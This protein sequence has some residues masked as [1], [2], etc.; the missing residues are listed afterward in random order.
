MLVLFT[1]DTHT[2]LIQR[3]NLSF[4]LETCS[5]Y[6]DALFVA[7]FAPVDFDR[8]PY[9]VRL[10]CIRH[11]NQLKGYVIYIHWQFSPPLSPFHTWPR[12]LCT[13]IRQIVGPALAVNITDSPL[14]DICPLTG[15]EA[16]YTPCMTYL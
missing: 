3:I 5:R 7:L 16:V 10:D 4:C 2:L 12:S 13:R 8:P 11:S 9:F 14:L 15:K 1:K 6:A